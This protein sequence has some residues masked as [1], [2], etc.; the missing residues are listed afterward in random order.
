M[1]WQK[2]QSGNPRG[3]A[4]EKTFRDAVRLAVNETAKDKKGRQVKK[5]RLL[6]ERLV[7]EAIDGNVMALKEVADRLDGK[8][9]QQVD[10]TVEEV[11]AEEAT[12]AALNDIIAYHARRGRNG[13]AKKANG[14]EEPDSVH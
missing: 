3:R 11:T 14:S 10:L 2:G 7:D 8:A 4:V 9:V 13:T 1:A 6:A 12:D 5:L